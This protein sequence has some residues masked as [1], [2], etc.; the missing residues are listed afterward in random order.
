M[1]KLSLLFLLTIT[2]LSSFIANNLS[3]DCRLAIQSGNVKG[4]VKYFSSTIEIRTEE[5]EG[6]FSKQQAEIVL[7]KFFKNNPPKSF[8][9]LHKGVSPGGAKYAIGN[10]KSSN[11]SF[12]VY[13][14]MKKIND[15]YLIDTIDISEE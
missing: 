7:R 10:Y 14:K 15:Q 3:D 8:T 6:T 12:R 11:M 4:L 13:I 1:R 9:Y 2:F 5:Q